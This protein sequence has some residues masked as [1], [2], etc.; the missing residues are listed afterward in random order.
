MPGG[1]ALIDAVVLEEEPSVAELVLSAERVAVAVPVPVVLGA[2]ETDAV[3]ESEADTLPEREGELD[4]EDERE[5]LT[6]D[7]MLG[8]GVDERHPVTTSVVGRLGPPKF[9]VARL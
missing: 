2:A 3:R 4:R 9:S 8:E 6:D 1:V 7:E 5:A